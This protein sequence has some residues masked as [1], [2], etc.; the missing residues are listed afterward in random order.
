MAIPTRVRRYLTGVL[1]R[2]SLIMSNAGHLFI[3][4]LTTYMSSLDEC[5]CSLLPILHLGCLFA[6]ELRELFVD[7][8]YSVFRT[9]LDSFV[10][11]SETESMS[12][13]Y[14][15]APSRRSSLGTPSL[16]CNDWAIRLEGSE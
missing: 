12:G 15:G 7:F 14:P 3:C 16:P 1:T 11:N 5:L 9:E 13:L 8:A 4:F 6:T 2:I 10:Y